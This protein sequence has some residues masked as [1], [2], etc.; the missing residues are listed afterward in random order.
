LSQFIYLEQK[1]CILSIRRENLPLI[2]FYGT[3][4]N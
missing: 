1:L 2:L 4:Q 3:V